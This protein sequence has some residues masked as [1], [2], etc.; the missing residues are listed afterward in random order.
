MSIVE[1]CVFVPCVDFVRYVQ[2]DSFLLM[3]DK[4]AIR[5]EAD[6]GDHHMQQCRNSKLY[7]NCFSESSN[8]YHKMVSSSSN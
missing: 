2:G 7:E 5:Q 1:V 8:K 4:K 3:K 6:T